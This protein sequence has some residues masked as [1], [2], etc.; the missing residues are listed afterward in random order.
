MTQPVSFNQAL[1]SAI[2]AQRN[3]AMNALANAEAK[4]AVATAAIHEQDAK[5]AD[6]EKR[7]AEYETPEDGS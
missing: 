4:L 5:I 3:A 7:L 2:E 1:V 6:L